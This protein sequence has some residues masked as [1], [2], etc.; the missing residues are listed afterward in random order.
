M[1][2]NAAYEVSL[3][4]NAGIKQPFL[5]YWLSV[6]PLFVQNLKGTNLISWKGFSECNIQSNKEWGNT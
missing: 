3:T 4:V 1:S 5:D 2:V 6:N